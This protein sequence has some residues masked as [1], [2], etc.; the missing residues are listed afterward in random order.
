MIARGAKIKIGSR[1]LLNS[2]ETSN[3]V[4]LPHRVILN[5]VTIGLVT[6]WDAVVFASEDVKPV[7]KATGNMTRAIRYIINFEQ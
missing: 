7:W 6:I 2:S 5:S 1:V 4:G 3:S